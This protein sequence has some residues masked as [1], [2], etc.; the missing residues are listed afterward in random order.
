M[1]IL[2][3]QVCISSLAEE[4][5]CSITVCSELEGAEFRNLPPGCYELEGQGTRED[6][7][8]VWF[9]HVTLELPG[10]DPVSKE[11]VYQLV[12]YPK[13]SEGTVSARS[14]VRSVNSP[15]S[16][17]SVPLTSDELSSRNAGMFLI[18]VTAAVFSLRML[19]NQTGENA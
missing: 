10:K 6:Q 4:A 2:I 9:Q 17:R 7:V 1:M 5:T 11:S 19:Q 3:L 13:F 14:T 15:S 16:A 12:L 18:S 8:P